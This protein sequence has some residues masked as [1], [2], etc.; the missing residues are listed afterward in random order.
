MKK[1]IIIVSLF[2]LIGCSAKPNSG[3]D[4]NSFSKAYQ[5]ASVKDK[6]FN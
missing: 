6:H 3:I 5:K 4:Y 1:I 2:L